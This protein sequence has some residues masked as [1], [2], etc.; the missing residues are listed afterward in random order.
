MF[1]IFS[2][3]TEMSIVMQNMID[4]PDSMLLLAS[5]Q[6]RIFLSSLFGAQTLGFSSFSLM[7]LTP[8]TYKRYG[9][10]RDCVTVATVAGKSN[11]LWSRS[12]LSNAR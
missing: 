10:D 7:R 1:I 8:V 2:L 11:W 4:F 9:N 6:G 12:A 5:I 3:K